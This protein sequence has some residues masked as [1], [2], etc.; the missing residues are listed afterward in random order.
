M[1]ALVLWTE[2]SLLSLSWAYNTITA[3]LMSW[4]S[5]WSQNN[6]DFVKAPQFIALRMRMGSS[7]SHMEEFGVY[8]FP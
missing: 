2:V 4:E 8:P 5:D 7:S 3:S 1:K 6:S